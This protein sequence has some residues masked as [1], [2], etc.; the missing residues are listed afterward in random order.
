MRSCDLYSDCF[1]I[2]IVAHV[3]F[4]VT[5][6]DHQSMSQERYLSWNNQRRFAFDDCHRLFFALSQFFLT[7]LDPGQLPFGAYIS[8]VSLLF[9]LFA[10]LGQVGSLVDK[11]AF[12][13]LFAQR[14][15]VEECLAALPRE[16]LN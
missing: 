15:V 5:R 2:G 9:L 3:I 12:D 10:Q 16:V 13:E 11:T 7:L 4:G 6:W 14:H 8:L 1:D